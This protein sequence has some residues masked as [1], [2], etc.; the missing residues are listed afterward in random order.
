MEIRP[1][2]LRVFLW[3]FFQKHWGVLKEDIMA[4]FKEFHSRRKFEKS[5]NA[6]FVS[7]IPKK[8]EAADVKDFHPVSLVGGMYKINSKVQAN[9]LKSVLGKIVRLQENYGVCFSS[10][11][12][13][14]GLCLKG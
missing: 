14:Y 4:V 1:Q 13:M 9:M 3:L 6:T 2:Y 5:F 8:A 10:C 12:G 7:L 11:L